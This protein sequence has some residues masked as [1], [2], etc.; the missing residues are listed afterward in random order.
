MI[1]VWPFCICTNGGVPLGSNHALSNGNEPEEVTDLIAAFEQQNQCRIIL[2]VFLQ[3]HKGYMD[4]QWRAQAVSTK[5]HEQ[6][7]NPVVLANVA[8]WAGDYKTLMA[9]VSRL[10]YALDFQLALN[11]FESAGHKKA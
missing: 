10:L 9:V 3:L 5:D 4:C 11:E 1:G 8:V 6:L 7:P 2:T